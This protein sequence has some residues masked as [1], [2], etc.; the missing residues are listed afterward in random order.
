MKAYKIDPYNN[1]ITTLNLGDDFREISK[2]IGCDLFCL[3][4]TFANRDTLY[5]DDEGLLK[6]EVT[7]GFTLNGQF[8]A[9]NGILLGCDNY[10][11]SMDVQT[12]ELE[13]AK[14]I[15]FPPPCFEITDE[16]REKAIA[17]WN[18]I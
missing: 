13:I 8:F 3:A 12:D 18:L 6:T 17:G 1:V 5:V 2:N 10:G 7:R 11:E 15:T 4:A 14:L 16:Y 9:G